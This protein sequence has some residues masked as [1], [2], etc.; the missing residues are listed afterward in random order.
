MGMTKL[1]VFRENGCATGIL[2]WRQSSDERNETPTP[3]LASIGLPVEENLDR[4]GAALTMQGS[5]SEPRMD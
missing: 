3:R 4:Q 5:T 1:D 2:L